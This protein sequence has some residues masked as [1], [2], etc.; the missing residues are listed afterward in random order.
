MT[1]LEGESQMLGNQTIYSSAWGSP[2]RGSVELLCPKLVHDPPARLIS[3]PLHLPLAVIADTSV[4]HPS[5]R[6]CL[7]D[8]PPD[9]AA[10]APFALA[11]SPA[12]ALPPPAAAGLPQPPGHPNCKCQSAGKAL[13]CTV[14][15]QGQL[16]KLVHASS[17]AVPVQQK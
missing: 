1:D 14:P 8:P 3:L 6:R 9:R 4:V 2:S 7:W 15:Q 10:K 16:P 5:A 11:P 13:T 17:Q 12:A